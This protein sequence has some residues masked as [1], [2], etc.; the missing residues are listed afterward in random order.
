[1][2]VCFFFAFSLTGYSAD[3]FLVSFDSVTKRRKEKNKQKKKKKK[4]KKV[5]ISYTLKFPDWC[6]TMLLSLLNVY[7]SIL[8]FI[9]SCGC[10]L[11]EFTNVY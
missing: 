9:S 1:M 3:V 2:L 4:K 7:R 6:F 8:T 10:S 5:Y 11:L